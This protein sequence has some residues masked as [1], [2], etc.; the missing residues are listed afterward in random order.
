MFLNIFVN[1]TIQLT[2]KYFSHI[3]ETT[4]YPMVHTI[5]PGK[6]NLNGKSVRQNGAKHSLKFLT[7][8]APLAENLN[9]STSVDFLTL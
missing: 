6:Q 8:G 1:L 7:S 4:T 5:C 3:L 2:S 9:F